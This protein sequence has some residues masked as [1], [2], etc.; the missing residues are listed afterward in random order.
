[1]NTKIHARMLNIV[2]NPVIEPNLFPLYIGTPIK[3]DKV[4]NTLTSN[5]INA[6]T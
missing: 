1:M 3:S 4:S 6:N 5:K 2:K